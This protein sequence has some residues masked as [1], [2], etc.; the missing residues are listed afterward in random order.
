MSNRRGRVLAVL[1]ATVLTM[2]MA[3]CQSPG[4]S[5]QNQTETEDAVAGGTLNLLGAGDI[6]Y[7][8]PNVSYYSVGYLN[9]RMWARQL[10]T[11]PAVPDQTTE[12]VPDLA[13]EIPTM[14]NGGVS[15]DGL[16]YTITL[17]D[18]VSWNSSPERPVVAADFVR[19]VKRTCNPGSAVRRDPELP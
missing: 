18:G 7:M 1:L 16:T 9:L 14:D 3:A 6:D 4:G 19:G 13:A 15:A 5:P 10:F 11:Y 12:P 17:R 2:L 8:D